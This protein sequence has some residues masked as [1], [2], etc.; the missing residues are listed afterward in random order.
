[1][2]F[3]NGDRYTLWPNLFRECHR[4]AFHLETRDS[5]AVP[6]EAERIARFLNDEPPPDP[7]TPWQ[8]L[9][10]ETTGRGVTVSRV[11]VIT[12]PHT[13]YHRWL[14]SATVH[15]VNAGEDIRYVPRHLAGNVPS[16]DWWLMDGERVAYNLVADDGTQAGIGITTD[17]R[18]VDYC[19]DVK[20]RLWALATPYAEYLDSVHA[21]Q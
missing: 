12:V 5:Y 19:A 2:Q 9:M 7:K 4:E 3:R 21:R 1:M 8:D 17:P 16:D 15:N 20:R 10:R 6:H 18:I 14:L 11:R 13:D